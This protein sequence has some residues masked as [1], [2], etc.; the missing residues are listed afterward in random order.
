MGALGGKI[1]ESFKVPLEWFILFLLK[2]HYVFSDEIEFVD[3]VKFL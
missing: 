1:F 3:R 2:S